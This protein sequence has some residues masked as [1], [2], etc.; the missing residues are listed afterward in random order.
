MGIFQKG[1]AFLER[2]FLNGSMHIELRK[3]LWVSF[4]LTSVVATLLMGISFY[5]RFAAQ[6]AQTT[7]EGNDTRM[8]DAAEQVTAHFRNMIKVS[9]TLYYRV[10]KGTDLQ[11]DTISDDFRLIYEMNKDYVESIALFSIDGNLICATP[12]SHLRP[13]FSLQKEAWYGSALDTEENIRFGAPQVSRVFRA[14]GDGYTR[15]IPM[16]RMVQLTMGDQTKRGV[17]LINLRYDVLQDMLE[18][19]MVGEESYVYLA[20]ENGNLLYHP[21]QDQIAAGIMKEE[22]LPLLM[23]SLEGDVQA[24]PYTFLH[25]TIGYTGWHMVG[26]SKGDTPSLHNWKTR[27]FILFLLA[28]FLNAMMLINFY[29]SRKVTEP[30]HRLEGAVKRIQ[31]GD[32]NT[33]IQAS[34]VYEIQNLSNAIEEMERNLKQLMEDI[35][36][37]HEAKRKSDLMV[38]QNQINPHF[39]YNTLDTFRGLALEQGNRELSDMI[40]A[41]SQMFKYSVKYEAEMV[42]IN[43]ELDYLKHYIQLQQMRF[44]GRFTYEEHLE[45]DPANL[46]LEPCPRFVL[47]PIVENAIRHGLRDVRKDGHI[48]VTMGMR[49]RDFFIL[50]EDNGCGMDMTEVSLLNQRLSQPISGENENPG[51]EKAGI[52]IENVNRRI[53]MFCGEEYGLRISSNLGTGTQVEVSLPL[54]REALEEKAL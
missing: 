24:K 30:M 25:K 47:Q 37:E 50:V 27:S 11:Q 29:V 31:A 5:Y 17:L 53:K 23:S 10:I 12:N 9:D 14:E 54:Y 48:V 18:N 8:E 26:V 13:N 39:L 40:E 1:K 36:Q 6:S 45:C 38:L 44:P 4:T 42:N 51:E 20:G 3:L 43:A 49:R 7:W 46:L 2:R 16:S 52:G 21:M 28:F 35:V 34:G 19:V 33:K 41:L 32:L 22:T 15:V